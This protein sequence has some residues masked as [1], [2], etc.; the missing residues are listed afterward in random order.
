[1][2]KLFVCDIDNTLLNQRVG[3]PQANLDAILS[4]Q[5]AGV[6]VALASGRVSSGLSD[7]AEKLELKRFGGYVIAANGSYVKRMKD[8]EV[9]L[10][11]RIPLDRLMELTQE[12][13]ELGIH[14]SIQQG[15][16]L[17][18]SVED[19]AIRYNRG[20]IG[21]KTA[22]HFDLSSALIE[23]SNKIEVTGFFN[24]D[25]EP[26]NR[27]VAR[28]AEEYSLIRGRGTFLDVMPKGITKAS[29]M[30]VVM[31]DLGLKASEVAAIG[32]GE[33]DRAM[34]KA[35]GLSATLADARASL[36]EDVDHVVGTVEQAGLSH[37]AHLVLSKNAV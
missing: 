6:T 10:D 11:A 34:L 20:V 22:E 25:I 26:F 4:L 5:K 15:D 2:I 21:L 14:A 12:I 8:E 27:F 36:H 3:L 1:M 24:G 18:Y 29:G 31:K 7:L 33:N 37:F 16:V 30:A 23:S 28:H 9:L 32:D 19:E 17:Y 35:A 13:R